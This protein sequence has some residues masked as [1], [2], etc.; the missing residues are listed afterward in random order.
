MHHSLRDGSDSSSHTDSEQS[1]ASNEDRAA[2]KDHFYL[3][4]LCMV[5]GGVGLFTPYCTYVAAIDYFFYYYK[6]EFPSLSAI[7][8]LTYFLAAFFAATLNIVLVKMVCV[9]SRITFGYVV[10]IIC[11][12][13]VPL[14]DIG[15]DNCTIPTT[16]SFYITLLTV[17]SVGLGAGGMI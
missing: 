5:M 11:L 3:V 17:G 13:T 9:Y 4:Y 2:P 14:L 12:L 16:V 7:F 6:E 8:P 1:S 15:I 10:F